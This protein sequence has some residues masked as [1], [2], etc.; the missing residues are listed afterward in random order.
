M[1]Y[2]ANVPQLAPLLRLPRDEIRIERHDDQQIAVALY[3]R[4][5]AVY[6]QKMPLTDLPND[7][8]GIEDLE[9]HGVLLIYV[10]A[11]EKLV[12]GCPG[13]LGHRAA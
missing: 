6:W 9:R 3:T 12:G 10:A 13:V 11:V 4:E 7:L 1:P 8:I 5:G 2:R